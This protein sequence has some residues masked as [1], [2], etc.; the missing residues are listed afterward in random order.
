MSLAL[1]LDP[2]RDFG[3]NLV[4]RPLSKHH[5][6]EL[7]ARSS[8][9]LFQTWVYFGLLLAIGG[10]ASTTKFTSA[11]PPA[12]Q[13]TGN[14]PFVSQGSRVKNVSSQTLFDDF[15]YSNHK[16]LAKHGWIIRTAAGWPGVPGASWGNKGVSFPI[17]QE[18]PGNRLL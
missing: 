7:S 16:Q 1:I 17:A 8:V 5:Q 18:H 14:Q 15:N 13:L 9:M 2:L 4:V 6:A 11:P 3:K 12:R 10:G